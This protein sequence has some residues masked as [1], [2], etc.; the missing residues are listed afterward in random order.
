MLMDKHIT[1]TLFQSLAVVVST[2][3]AQTVAAQVFIMRDL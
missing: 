2:V 3:L 1:Q